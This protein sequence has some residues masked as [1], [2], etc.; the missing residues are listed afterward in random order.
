MAIDPTK[1]D[2]FMN[3]VFADLGATFHATLVVIGD[4]LGLY[5]ALAE[6]GPQTSGQLAKPPTAAAPWREPRAWAWLAVFHGAARSLA[7]PYHE[8]LARRLDHL[9]PGIAQ[10]LLRKLA[11]RRVAVRGRGLMAAF[12]PQLR[13][14]LLLRLRHATAPDLQEGL[15]PVLQLPAPGG[16]FLVK[17]CHNRIGAR[18]VCHTSRARAFISSVR[19]SPMGVPTRCQLASL[20]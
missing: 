14:A 17:P 13:C 19:P 20:G 6:G 12:R 3:Q 7:S 15:D 9:E 4:K 1:L 18:A 2:R 5:R 11:L 16:A 10:Y 8:S